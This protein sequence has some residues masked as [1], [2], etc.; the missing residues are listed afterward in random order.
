MLAFVFEHRRATADQLRRRFFSRGAASRLRHWLAQM[1]SGGHLEVVPGRKVNE[2]AIYRVGGGSPRGL[3]LIRATYG[4]AALRRR[5]SAYVQNEHFVLITECYMAFWEAVRAVGWQ[6][7]QW[8]DAIDVR[9]RTEADGVIPDAYF[10]V[11]RQDGV[12]AAFFLELERT[13]K[14]DQAMRRKLDGHRRFF[15]SGRYEAVFGTRSLRVLFVLAAS[16]TSRHDPAARLCDLSERLGAS[17]ICAITLRDLQ[18]AAG[19]A[20]LL[21]RC[22]R[23]AGRVD[24]YALFQGDRQ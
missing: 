22:W 23:R 16:R 14:S 18:A 19:S 17:F 21:E 8:D 6:L 3:E 11:R 10:C 1:R 12:K 5:Q 13:A 15:R 20:L 2:P 4:D 9:A 24:R 7:E